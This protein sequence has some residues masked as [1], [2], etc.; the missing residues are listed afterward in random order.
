MKI[1]VTGGSGFLGSHVADMLD[2][3]GHKET[4]FDKCSFLCLVFFIVK[5]FFIKCLSS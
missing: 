2:H 3:K 5:V 1:T 4:I